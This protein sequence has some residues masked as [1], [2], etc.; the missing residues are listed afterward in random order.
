[1]A[2]FY[3]EDQQS[4]TRYNFGMIDFKEISESLIGKVRGNPVAIS[5]FKEEIPEVYQ[6]KKVVPCS[7]V[8]HAMDKGE[9]VSFDKH[10]H[11]CTTG[12]YTAGVHEGTDEIRNGQYLAKNIPAY[13]DIGAEK[14]KTGEYVL[15]Q[16]TVIGVGAAPLSEVPE[17]IF[18]DWIVVVCTPHWAN[19]IGGARTVL[20]GTPPRGAAGSSFCSDLFA[21]PWHDDNVIITPGDLG[22]RMNNRLKPEEMFVVV[23]NKYLQSL[24]SIMTTTPDARAVLEATKPKESEYWEKRKRAKEAKEKQ[25]KNDSLKS[26]FESKLSMNWE[27]QAK[28]MIASTPPGIIEMAI[29]NVE[30]FAREKGIEE[31]TKSVVLEQMKSVGMDPDMIN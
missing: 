3:L 1:M 27:Q 29:N 19:F 16:K 12:V 25:S 26:D 30:D 4:K 2:A 28:D 11:D 10:H 17:G 6:K 24:L 20:D 21:T 22:G 8:R 23:P 13:T 7:I 31:I 5:L 14:I 18:V 9:I 15:P